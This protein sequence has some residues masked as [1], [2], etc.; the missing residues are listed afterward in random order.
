MTTMTSIRPVPCILAVFIAFVPALGQDLDDPILSTIPPDRP[1]AGPPNHIDESW[2]DWLERTGE[3]PPDWDTMPA[4]ALLPDLLTLERGGVETPIRTAEEWQARRERV[5]EL[6]QQWVIGDFPPAPG[7]VESE[8]R[9]SALPDG[10]REEEIELRFGPDGEARM[11]LILRTPP[12]EGPHPVFMTQWNHASWAEAA[13]LRGY[14]TARYAGADARDDTEAYAE[15]WPDYE[16]SRLARRAWGAMRVID[17]L[18]EREVLDADRIAVAGHSRNGKQSLIL[19]AFDPRVAAV[20]SSSGGTGGENPWRFTDVAYNNESLEEITWEFP[21]WFHPR[22]RFFIGHENRLPVE[23]TDLM[24][25]IAPRG[26]LLS[27]AINENEG[28]PWGVEQAFGSLQ[29]VYEWL[30]APENLAYIRRQGQH[31]LPADVLEQYFDFFD[32]VLDRGGPAPAN[33]R[34]YPYTFESW[35]ERS[36]EEIDPLD[37][38]DRTGAEP[39]RDDEGRPIRSAAEWS[40]RRDAIRERLLWLLGDDA[41]DAARRSSEAFVESDREESIGEVIGR[42]EVDS[43]ERIVLEPGGEAAEP[44]LHLYLP[45]SGGARVPVVLFLHGYT[46]QSGWARRIDPLISR[47]TEQGIAVA[48]FDFIGFGTRIEDGTDYYERRPRGSKLGRIIADARA[49]VGALE[50][51]ELVGEIWLAGTSL[52]GSVALMTAALDDRVAGVSVESGFTP[53]REASPAVEGAYAFSHQH[54]LAPRLGFFHGREE[55]IPVDFAEIIAAVAPR[56]VRVVAP[57]HDW[58]ADTDRVREAIDQAAPFW[59]LLGADGGLE[60]ET[61]PGFR[62]FFRDGAFGAAAQHAMADSIAAE[63][64]A[65][66]GEG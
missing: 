16:F 45:E 53:W 62:P 19:A 52:G 48:A 34:D 50:A 54:G 51:H 5:A 55:R 66:G 17:Y 35:L 46:Y 58:H 38:P 15:I 27:T 11:N 60:L 31:G 63:L 29:P 9:A 20:V 13:Y 49:A 14:A 36:G 26:L 64:R 12:E 25:L 42:P 39:L 57:E 33:R 4:R 37:F 1:S 8:V 24:S 6:Y 18:E 32:H 47:L 7:E 2:H 30:G 28:G 56:P 44:E 21:T 40:E 59:T 43:A 65:R 61:P 23:Q 10:G 41:E 22:L 3:R